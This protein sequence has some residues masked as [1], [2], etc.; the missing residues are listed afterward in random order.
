MPDVV[1]I[2]REAEG[3]LAKNDSLRRPYAVLLPDGRVLFSSEYEY[4]SVMRPETREQC[5]D[6][7]KPKEREEVL[8][9]LIQSNID[10]WELI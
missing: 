4:N 10:G 7:T 2:R 6:I 5:K 1:K 9:W 8:Q 3:V